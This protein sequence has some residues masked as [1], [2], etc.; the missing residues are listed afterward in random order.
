MLRIATDKNLSPW[1]S[2]EGRKHILD[3]YADDLSIFLSL[4]PGLLLMVDF[5]KAFDS[6]SFSF[7]N[8]ALKSTTS[9]QKLSPGLTFYF[10]TLRV[11]P[12]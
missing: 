5:S 9:P 6:I 10:T 7:L 3:G 1:K 12:V 11:S 2:L 8:K 4:L